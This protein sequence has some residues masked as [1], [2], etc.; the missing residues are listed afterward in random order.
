M[1]SYLTW[2]VGLL[3]VSGVLAIMVALGFLPVVSSV[4]S[5]V[6]E[7]LKPLARAAG[8][9]LAGASRWL[10][11]TV[12]WPE[13]R[14]DGTVPPSLRRGLADIFD[15]WVTVATV[16]LAGLLLWFSVTAYFQVQLNTRLAELQ[17]CRVELRKAKQ[18]ASRPTP[19]P[20]SFPWFR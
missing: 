16:G 18:P 10:W 15:D 4:V 17:V 12:I 3:G 6:A 8:D 9:F 19:A 14:Q 20:P 5:I 11:T 13:P 7:F 2:A 1:N